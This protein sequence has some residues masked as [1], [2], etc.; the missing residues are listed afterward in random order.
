MGGA[1]PFIGG[2]TPFAG[3]KTPFDAV[4]ARIHSGF[5]HRCN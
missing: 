3:G 1:T 4:S 5:V 2:A